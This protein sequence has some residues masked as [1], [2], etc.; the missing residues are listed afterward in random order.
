[1]GDES[2]IKNELAALINADEWPELSA[3]KLADN[4]LT[5]SLV[6]K[7]SITWFAGH[8]P[9]QAVLPGVVQVHWATQLAKLVFKHYCEEKVPCFKAANNVKFKTMIM[10]GQKIDLVLRYDEAKSAVR[11]SYRTADDEFSTGVIVFSVS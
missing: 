4:T 1:M 2:A 9:E 5:L 7:E 6:I 8:F 11:F 10:P 3:S